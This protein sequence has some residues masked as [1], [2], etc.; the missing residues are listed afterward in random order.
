MP[1]VHAVMTV[2]AAKYEHLAKDIELAMQQAV[3]DCMKRGVSL[4][5]SETI[6]KA[7]LDAREEVLRRRDVTSGLG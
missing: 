7:M 5:D 6:K 2:A 3:L 4:N 1:V